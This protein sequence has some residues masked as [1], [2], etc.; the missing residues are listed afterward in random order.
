MRRQGDGFADA[1][2]TGLPGEIAQR[3]REVGGV[4]AM[5]SPFLTVE[6]AYLLCKFIRSVDKK[7]VLAMGPIPV[8]GED[9]HY[10]KGF[11]VSARN[12]RTGA[13]WKRCCATLRKKIVGLEELAHGWNRG[14]FKEL[15]VAGG[16]K[17]QW[18][19]EQ[20]ARRFERLKLFVVQDL[21]PSPL[22]RLATYQLPGRGVC[23]TGRIVRES[24]RPT[25]IGPLGHPSADWRA[26]G[27][28]FVLG[29]FRATR[30][31]TMPESVLEEVAREIVYFSAAMGQVP[32]V[33]VDLKVN[34]L[35]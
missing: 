7:A 5:F 34:M 6:E 11:T 26:R 35:A 27:R 33:G 23:R 18:I 19:D 15:W 30:D 32:D 22:S 10:P 25:A 28:E 3:F 21:F 17:S 20:T 31:C 14:R 2:W 13:A 4:G 24:G 1:D 16:Y 12:A 29:D 9:E 8:V